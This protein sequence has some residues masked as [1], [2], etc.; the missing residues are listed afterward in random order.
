MRRRHRFVI[1]KLRQIW[2]VKGYIYPINIY[3]FSID[4]APNGIL[5]SATAKSIGKV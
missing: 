3:N 2:I 5:F 4:L 1:V